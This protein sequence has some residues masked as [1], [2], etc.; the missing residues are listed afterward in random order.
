MIFIKTDYFSSDSSPDKVYL[1]NNSWD[2]WFEFETVYNIHYR[3]NRIGNI[4]IGR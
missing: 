2:D 3:N 4:K 1:V